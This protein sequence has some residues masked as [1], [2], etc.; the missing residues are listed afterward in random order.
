MESTFSS[1]GTKS[2]AQTLPSTQHVQPSL[3]SQET[4]SVIRTTAGQSSLNQGTASEPQYTP[5]ETGL[6]TKSD[7]QIFESSQ[8]PQSS[9]LPSEIHTSGAQTAPYMTKPSS[10]APESTSDIIYGSQSAS[11]RSPRR[12][13][14]ILLRPAPKEV[15]PRAETHHN[16]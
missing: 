14:H 12:S 6:G 3:P 5:S 11:P 13:Y 8:G 4:P 15:S 1:E 9:S 16:Q 7:T 10:G 2:L